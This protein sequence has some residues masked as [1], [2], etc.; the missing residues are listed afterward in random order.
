MVPHSNAIPCERAVVIHA[1]NAP[2]AHAAVVRPR[3]LPVAAVVAEAGRVQEWLHL[4]RALALADDASRVGH[5]ELAGRLIRRLD[6]Q[7]ASGVGELR[8]AKVVEELH[9]DPHGQ[10]VV[11]QL[12]KEPYALHVLQQAR[13][14]QHHPEHGHKAD[15]GESD[16]LELGRVQERPARRGHSSEATMAV[17]VLVVVVFAPGGCLV[18]RSVASIAAGAGVVR[19]DVR[20]PTISEPPAAAVPLAGLGAI[21]AAVDGSEAGARAGAKVS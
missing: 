3:R 4:L 10:D 19:L 16:A 9:A 7:A 20:C 21:H 1:E 17:L 15:D 2:L 13:H 5:L 14:C 8:R 18:L 12:A 11:F 6:V